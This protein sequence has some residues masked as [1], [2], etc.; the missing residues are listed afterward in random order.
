MNLA[1]LCG[2][3]ERGLGGYIVSMHRALLVDNRSYSSIAQSVE[4]R[5]VKSA[6][7]QKYP[8]LI[9][10]IPCKSSIYRVFLTCI[11]N[12]T[13]I[14]RIVRGSLVMWKVAIC[15]KLGNPSENFTARRHL[16]AESNFSL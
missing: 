1:I 12:Y 5:T 16:D 13:V 10:K 11:T 7:I 2:L 4:R 6:E 9:L 8:F 14:T 15:N 3:Q